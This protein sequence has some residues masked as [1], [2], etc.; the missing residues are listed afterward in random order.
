MLQPPELRDLE[1]TEPVEKDYFQA[2]FLLS[3]PVQGYYRVKIDASL[4]D[5]EGTLWHT[6]PQVTMSVRVDTK[7]GLQQ[8]GQKQMDSGSVGTQQLTGKPGR[9]FST[10]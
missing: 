7:E 8:Q 6:G 4:L 3:L 10:D 5:S 1:K 2:Q 9:S